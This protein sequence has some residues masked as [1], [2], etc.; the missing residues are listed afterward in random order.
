[1]EIIAK[2]KDSKGNVMIG[3]AWVEFS[4]GIQISTATQSE[5]QKE[6]EA[7]IEKYSI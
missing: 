5:F 2:Y 1:M 6:L 4:G 3:E 7:V